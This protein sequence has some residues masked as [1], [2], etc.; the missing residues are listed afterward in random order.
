MTIRGENIVRGVCVQPTELGATPGRDPCV[1]CVCT[2]QSG[3]PW[4]W[5]SLEVAAHV[6]RRQADGT[7]AGDHY[8]GEVL[9][10]SAPFL[11]HFRDWCCVI[12]GSG[13]EDEI[14]VNAFI[15]GENPF[16]DGLCCGERGQRVVG[17]DATG[18][19]ERG[20]ESELRWRV[21]DPRLICDELVADHLPRW[22][23]CG[24]DGIRRVDIHETAGDD[25]Q[26]LMRAFDLEINRVIPKVIRAQGSFDWFWPDQEFMPRAFLIGEGS[27]QETRQVMRHRDGAVVGVGSAV[28]N[29]VAHGQRTLR[30]AWLK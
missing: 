20:A 23:L 24:V 1:G 8:L 25:L 30:T 11:H 18:L 28:D 17:E 22:S 26:L 29:V 2:D 21:I 14:G 5:A 4:R 7:Q 10:N 3:L 15:Q 12:S 6:S 9:A 27:R 13:I 19:D 16:G